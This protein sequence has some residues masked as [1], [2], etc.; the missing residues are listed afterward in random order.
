MKRVII[1]IS[2]PIIKIYKISDEYLIECN[3]LNEHQSTSKFLNYLESSIYLW[4]FLDRGVDIFN[5]T[6]IDDYRT[7]RTDGKWIW[8]ADLNFYS[9]NHHFKWPEEFLIHWGQ[10][11]K[12]SLSEKKVYELSAEYDKQLMSIIR[13]VKFDNLKLREYTVIEF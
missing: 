7:L 1:N 6:V 4:I 13:E 5:S 2:T 10:K 9:G 8:S 11:T 12:V 3:K